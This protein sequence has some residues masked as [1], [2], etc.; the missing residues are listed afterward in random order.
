MSVSVNEKKCWQNPIPFLDKNNKLGGIPWWSS[1]EDSTL[2]LPRVL[3]YV[4]RGE[5]DPA[6]HKA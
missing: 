4:L 2:P 5:K 1:G 6:S 3:V